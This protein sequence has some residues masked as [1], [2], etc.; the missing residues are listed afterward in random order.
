MNSASENKKV[1]PIFVSYYTP[2]Y[3]ACA[4]RLRD[5]LERFGLDHDIS[6]IE[7]TRTWLDAIRKRPQF[8]LDKLGEY[9]DRP[10]VWL[11]SDAEIVSYPDE[12]L[13]M[14]N[15]QSIDFA[16]VL[17]HDKMPIG[18]TLWFAQS[19]LSITLLSVWRTYHQSQP[20]W[21]GDIA[22]MNALSNIKSTTYF[23]MKQLSHSYGAIFDAP[24]MNIEPP[25]IKQYQYSREA[26]KLKPRS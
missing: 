9:K 16:C 22:L 7:H 25:V 13:E 1:T 6:E 2:D 18:F 8:I 11:D 4:Q 10:V 23:K 19:M 24:D 21:R 12:L 15:D 5:S 26:Q 20:D 14:Q 3:S 17:R